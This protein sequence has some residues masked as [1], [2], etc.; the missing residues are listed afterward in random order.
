[1]AKFKVGDKVKVSKPKNWPSD[2]EFK[3][4]NAEGTVEVWSDWPDV[5]DPF[6]DYVYVMIDKATGEGKIYEGVNMIFTED[7]LKKLY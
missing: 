1:M 4:D 6:S 3:L 5:M 2:S 7:S